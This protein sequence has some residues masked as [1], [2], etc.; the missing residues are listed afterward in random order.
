[1]R[2]REREEKGT[3]NFGPLERPQNIGTASLSLKIQLFPGVSV[4][5]D[6]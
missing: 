3:T 1:M 4:G 6:I 2:A 5:Y